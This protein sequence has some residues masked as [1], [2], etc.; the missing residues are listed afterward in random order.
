MKHLT[1]SLWSLKPRFDELRKINEENLKFRPFL[2]VK[3]KNYV[4]KEKILNQ[5]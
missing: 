1:I 4:K 3:L 2:D 5:L